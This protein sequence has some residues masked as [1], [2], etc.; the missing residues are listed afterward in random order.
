[1]EDF[2]MNVDRYERVHAHALQLHA[3]LCLIHGDGV[4][5]FRC[6]IDDLRND[7]L[8]AACD[9]APDTKTAFRAAR[10]NSAAAESSA[11]RPAATN[12]ANPRV[13]SA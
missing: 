1:M 3:L 10:S 5:A 8:W 7:Y 11:N 9:M 13:H 6:L 2:K 12:D 4:K